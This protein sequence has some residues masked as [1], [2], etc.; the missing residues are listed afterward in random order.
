M[1]RLRAAL[2][3]VCG[4]ALVRAAT[5]ANDTRAADAYRPL[6]LFRDSFFGRTFVKTDYT[7]EARSCGAPCRGRCGAALTRAVCVAAAGLP[8]QVRGDVGCATR[9]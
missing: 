7:F 2:L 1:R 4:A 6:I 3:C 9:A 8:G 5:G